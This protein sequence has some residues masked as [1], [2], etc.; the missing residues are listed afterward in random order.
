MSKYRT[1][2]KA[3]QEIKRTDPGSCISECFIRQL[4]MSG[5]IKSNTSGNRKYIDL[6][7]LDRYLKGGQSADGIKKDVFIGN[8]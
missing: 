5:C 8:N 6:D 7:E 2:R 3:Y 4:V 1:I